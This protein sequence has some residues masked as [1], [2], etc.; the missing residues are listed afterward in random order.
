MNFLRLL[1]LFFAVGCLGEKTTDKAF[2]PKSNKISESRINKKSKSSSMLKKTG[3]FLTSGILVAASAWVASNFLY[4][5]GGSESF[6]DRFQYGE[7]NDK[8]F[9]L[10][11]GGNRLIKR[12]SEELISVG[13]EMFLYEE[14]FESIGMPVIDAGDEFYFHQL[15]FNSEPYSSIVTIGSPSERNNV[16]ELG[17][18]DYNFQYD[19]Q[20]VYTKKL[21]NSSDGKRF[22]FHQFD[23]QSMEIKIGVM[24]NENMLNFKDYIITDCKS[25]RLVNIFFEKD[26]NIEVFWVGTEEKSGDEGIFRAVFSSSS[27][28]V[29]SSKDIEFIKIIPGKV[30]SYVKI[31]PDMILLQYFSYEKNINLLSLIDFDA[32]KIVD[33]IDSPVGE[34]KIKIF[35]FN[36]GKGAVGD[37]TSGR[38]WFLKCTKTEVDLNEKFVTSNSIDKLRSTHFGLVEL[39]AQENLEVN[40]KFFDTDGN[41]V[42]SDIF[43]VS[44]NAHNSLLFGSTWVCLQK[45]NSCLLSYSDGERMIGLEIK[46]DFEKK[47]LN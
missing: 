15:K 22:A 40:L 42:Y 39:N 12:D 19:P 21:K 25:S 45:G 2:E 27:P 6:D 3:K 13:N 10:E 47:T 35:N 17:R 20:R 1:A 23:R 30:E 11:L 38:V 28:T 33:T 9:D 7:K 31:A 24:S 46:F 36:N 16:F 37:N 34:N 14:P 4:S 32:E 18:F 44:K 29:Q 26:E 8:I 5:N 43:S 41:N